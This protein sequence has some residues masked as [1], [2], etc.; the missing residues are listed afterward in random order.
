MPGAIEARLRAALARIP[1]LA[2]FA[3]GDLHIA[4]LGGLTNASFRIDGSAGAFALRLAGPGTGDYIDRAAEATNARRA[5]RA[6][7]AP[8]VVFADPRDGIL[9]TR[10]IDGARPMDAE[11]LRRPAGC[12][13]A[14]AVLRR[15]HG[16]DER[17]A[18][19]FDPFAAIARYEALAARRGVAGAA[20]FADLRDRIATLVRALP[21]VSAPCHGDP[22]PA[23]ILDDGARGWLIDFEYAGNFDPLWDLAYLAVEADLE[24]AGRDRLFR[25]YLGRRPAADEARRLAAYAPLCDLLAAAWGRARGG[26][27]A[28][29]ASGRLARCR[30]RL[31]RLSAGRDG[32]P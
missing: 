27:P 31:A 18:G 20:D 6:G 32:A 30:A 2:G 10:F 8:E 24:D 25:A 16:M 7:L 21:A 29:E 23:N 13:R 15:L 22:A 19:V 9:V 12:A 5:A 1:P 26:A 28:A 17:F 11:A 14:A 3:P 4:P